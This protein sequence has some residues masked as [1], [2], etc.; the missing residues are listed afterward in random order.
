MCIHWQPSLGHMRARKPRLCTKAS[1]LLRR[2]VFFLDGTC[3]ICF[4]AYYIGQEDAVSVCYRSM[5]L[6]SLSAVT[7]PCDSPLLTIST[8]AP[9]IYQVN[10]PSNCA[11]Q[12]SINVRMEHTC[13][14]SVIRAQTVV[15]ALHELGWS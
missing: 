9:L 14:S 11:F 7:T 4:I 6:A 13:I 10:S 15:L 12:P 2:L 8:L 1:C 5:S 3:L